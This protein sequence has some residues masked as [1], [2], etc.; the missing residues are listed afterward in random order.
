MARLA[1]PTAI[2]CQ[3][4]KPIDSPA[5]VFLLVGNSHAD[6]IKAA[7]TS[8]AEE[9]NSTVWFLVDNQPLIDGGVTP[10][11]VVSEALARNVQTIVLH[12]APG[13]IE[14]GTVLELVDSAETAHLR[15]AFIMPV[16]VWHRLVPEALWKNIT[17]H[18]PLPKQS[19]YDYQAANK[20]LFDALS[21]IRN[22][23]FQVYETGSVFCHGACELISDEGKPL[24]FDDGHLTLTGAAMLRPLFARV[25]EESSHFVKL[26]APRA[27]A[28]PAGDVGTD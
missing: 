12:F 4:T 23:N 18:D 6:S 10:K 5:Q 3:L 7:F 20:A 28:Q 25:I 17:A 15:V 13:S 24:Y 19:L 22:G 8:V 2:S 9:A 26:R 14:P 1:H 11:R 27:A 21:A 16:P